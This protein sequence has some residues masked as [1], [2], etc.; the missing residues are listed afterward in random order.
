[1]NKIKRLCIIPA[2]GGSKRFPGKN[3]ALIGDRP[4][5]YHT[6][7]TVKDYFD[8]I[9]ISTDCEKIMNKLTMYSI[10]GKTSINKRHPELATDESRVIDTVKYYFKIHGKDYDQIWL[11]L[12][13]CPLRSHED[14]D[15]AQNYLDNEKSLDGV[16]GV[17]DSE[18][19]I[20]LA[21]RVNNKKNI[22]TINE[23]DKK[24][25]L[26]NNTRTQ[27]HV[28]TYRPNGAFYGMWCDSFKESK[29]FF[30]GVI[31]AYYMPRER[32][33]DIDTD[34]DLIIANAILKGG[35]D[36]NSIWNNNI[37]L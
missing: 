7:M 2:R 15:G 11:C 6:Y 29:N 8:K 13:T 5:I 37:Q 34:I 3:M 17:T 4:L 22:K 23:I 26:S 9:I 14:I 10:D 24:S 30:K 12:P 18:F 35:K 1:M 21:F 32:S 27:D 25:Y 19:P 28:K 16:I 31:G 36:E 20:S 33:I